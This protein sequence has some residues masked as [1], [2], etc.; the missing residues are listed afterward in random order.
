MQILAE[1]HHAEGINTQGKTVH[2]NAVRAVI[3]RGQDLLMVYSANVGD[4]KF[5]GGG[6]DKGETHEQALHREIQEECG[7]S[8]LQVGEEIC[9]TVEYD[10]PM[11]QEYDVFKMTSYY[12]PC[13]VQDGFGLQKLDDYEV[14]L[15]FTPVWIDIKKAIEINKV[16]LNSSHPPRWLGREVLVLEYIRGLIA[17]S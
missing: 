3:L 7:M 2:R 1:I 10:L 17:E 9:R 8:L 5:P 16:L 14:G 13:E 4:Y 6:V 12:Y 11:E 15:G